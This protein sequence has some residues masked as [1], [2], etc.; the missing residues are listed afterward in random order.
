MAQQKGQAEINTFVGGLVTDASPL[1]FPP[2]TSKTDINM[3]LLTDGSRKRSLGIDLEVG[4]VKIVTSV[5]SAGTDPLGISTFRWEN[6]GSDPTKNILCVQ[7]SNEVKFFD[8]SAT[9]LSSGLIGTKLFTGA[10]TNTKYSFSSVD[11]N[12]VVA[13][14]TN[15]IT[16]VQYDEG[17]LSY[18]EDTIKI[19]DFFGVED[20]DG[21]DD[22]TVGSG[23]L[24]RPIT[25]SNQHLYNLRNQTF[26]IPRMI[27]T[28]DNVSLVDPIGYFYFAFGYNKYPSNS[29][30][31]IP[32]LYPNPNAES[33]RISKRFSP[34][35]LQSNPLGSFRA[36]QG[37]FII[38]LLNRGTSRLEQFAKNNV[39][40]PDLVYTLSPLPED[41]TIGGP[42]I[43]SEFSGRVW[44]GGFGGEVINGDA[45]SPNL[46]SYIAFSQLV[47]DPSMITLCYQEG[48]PT[49]NT[50][51]DIVDTDGGLIRISNAYD[52]KALINLG[53]DLMVGASNGWWRIY[54]GNDSGFTGTNYVVS[55][56]TD[57]GVRGTGSV[58]QAENSILYWSDDGIYHLQRN[59]LGDWEA[60]SISNNRI[61]N[62]YDGISVN[63]KENVVG[64]YDSFQKKVRWLYQNT[65][66][67]AQQQK[68]LIF[69]LNLNAFW[70]RHVS[71]IVG[72]GLPIV[73]SNF[74]TNPYKVSDIISPVSLLGST[75]TVSGVAVTVTTED[76]SLDASL[77]EV[78]YMIVTKI[79]PQLEYT[80]GFYTN[81]EFIDWKSVNG[82]GVDAPSILVTGTASSGDNIKYKQMPYIV[83]HMKRTENGFTTDVN[84]DF[85]P[86]NQSSCLLQSQ[87]DWTNSANANKWGV[88]TQ[89]YRY[90]RVYM[91][92][93]INDPFD[94]GYETIVTKNKLRGRGRALALK[95]QSEPKKEMHIYGWSMILL[96]N[97]NE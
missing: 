88:P 3:D 44:Y 79:S 84:G 29:D 5:L 19:R 92:V 69:S 20:F 13:N 14:G 2:N 78:G 95:F 1:T 39:N 63:S 49:S 91:P 15:V 89:V 46:T 25:L 94:T 10:P 12:L 47:N 27:T 30:S 56:V 62:L 11:G 82:I 87:W 50:E 77:N 74:Q 59:Q 53:S 26:G 37:Y 45:K 6:V 18:S 80:F 43:V 66:N 23:L 21:G 81:T 24:K 52:I 33:D 16:I 61:Q 60:A 96:G 17:V 65:I 36:P 48:D 58:V 32:Y 4:N 28:V 70:E 22:L 73:L 57:R 67:T 38:D 7:V 75:I 76:A 71:Q 34:R 55:K 31:V 9:P 72:N 41:K 51:P 42:T 8:M 64:V 93:D 54:G 35:D 86:I 90:R 85:I 40:F 68:E 83:T 97:A